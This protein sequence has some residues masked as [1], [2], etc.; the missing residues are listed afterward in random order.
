M[1]LNVTDL[2][3]TLR[4]SPLQHLY[5]SMWRYPCSSVNLASSTYQKE[6]TVGKAAWCHGVNTRSFLTRL[7]HT[8][9]WFPLYL[10]C[11]WHAG[12]GR[13]EVPLNR[14]VGGISTPG[15]PL[16]EARAAGSQTA[17]L[18]LSKYQPTSF[19]FLFFALISFPPSIVLFIYSCMIW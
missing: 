3:I 13:T 18:L 8:Q 2:A 5:L 11:C 7:S 1:P 4:L 12:L 9:T 14:D 6:F 16:Y 15:V 19:I 17:S 10:H